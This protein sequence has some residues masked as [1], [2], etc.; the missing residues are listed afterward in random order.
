MLAARTSLLDRTAA[1]LRDLVTTWRA[2]HPAARLP[3]VRALARSAGVSHVTLLRALR[4]LS[5]QGLVDIVPAQGIWPAGT[6]P[7]RDPMASVTPPAG[8]KWQDLAGHIGG[9]LLTGTYP[10]GRALPS[11]KALRRRYGVSYETLVKALRVLVADGTLASYGA[12]YR[13]PALAAARHRTEGEGNAAARRVRAVFITGGERPWPVTSDDKRF[14]ALL[15]ALETECALADL[16]LQRVC[17]SERREGFVTEDGVGPRLPGSQEWTLGYLVF[18]SGIGDGSPL[19]GQLLPFGKPVAVL[20]TGLPLAVPALKGSALVK[21]FE[22]GPG[23]GPGRDMGRYLLSLGHRRV[24]YVSPYHAA[25][26]SRERVEG[27]SQAFRAAGLPGAVVPCADDRFA[28]DRDYLAAARARL[29]L[30]SYLDSSRLRRD[31]PDAL[32]SKAGD[33]EES[34]W[35]L[36]R[37]C[38]VFQGLSRLFAQ[39][40]ADRAVTAWVA[41]TDY[42]ALLALEFLKGRSV[43]VPQDI[44]VAGFDDLE[45]LSVQANLTTYRYNMAA[46]AQHMLRHILQPCYPPLRRASGIVRIGGMIIERGT[47]ARAR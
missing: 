26:W 11:L 18:R 1:Y 8:A 5:G 9:E 40:L 42:I 22:T 23:P 27:L 28:D 24:A 39:A 43:R 6:R 31:M 17:Y 35:R 45:A 16:E 14:D 29:S 38:Q 19:L 47:T 41:C 25:A 30:E 2:S 10:A 36:L 15:R 44:S 4:Q 32:R 13:V 3:G 37:D 46:V 20:T 12:S 7:R 21:T 34:L 33:L